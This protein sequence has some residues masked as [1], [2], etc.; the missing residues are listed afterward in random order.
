MQVIQMIGILLVAL[1]IPLAL[2]AIG[3]RQFTSKP[4]PAPETGGLR[5]ALEQAAEKTWKVPEAISD[6]RGIFVAS[7]PGNSLQV[8]ELIEKTVQDLH[9]IILSAPTG[10]SQGERLLVQMPAS[11]ASSFE[12]RLHDQNFVQKQQADPTEGNRLYELVLSPP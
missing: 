4:Q 8:R 10:Q 1:A 11:G 12:A 7:S 6:G 2:V 3:V 9:G 5:V